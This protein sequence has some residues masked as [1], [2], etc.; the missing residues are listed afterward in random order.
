MGG[1]LCLT[2]SAGLAVLLCFSVRRIHHLIV[3]KIWGGM[4]K[5]RGVLTRKEGKR[6]GLFVLDVV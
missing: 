4:S 1:Y 6:D 2:C 3:E 5:E